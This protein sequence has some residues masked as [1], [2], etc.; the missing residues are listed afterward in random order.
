M[1]LD[2]L[3]PPD[4]QLGSLLL[5]ATAA[6]LTSILSAIVGMGG[7]ITL[8]A[9]MLVF[10]D[11]LVA[12]P[13]HAIIQLVSN[14]TRAVAQWQHVEWGIL[15]RYA[16]PLLPL[17]WLSLQ[18]AQEIP[19]NL[20]RAFIGVFVCVATWRPSWFLLGTHPEA[21]DSNRRFFGLGI[22]VGVFN[23][24]FG[25]T[26]PLI[27][28]FFLNLGLQ[29]FAIIGTKAAC[30]LAGHGVKI[31]V[32]GLAGFA[33]PDWLGALILLCGCVVVGTLVGTRMLKSVSEEIFIRLYKTVLTLVALYLIVRNGLMG[34]GA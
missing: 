26:G 12:I 32:F 27:A 22:V 3:V 34:W 20:A 7:G 16:L 21:I 4:L 18:L 33:Y 9:L 17:G 31:L 5:L 23:V 6:L 14:G 15:W 2:F 29:R 11:P 13:L 30:Q 8:L 25:A 1:I 19:P 28:P 24:T 10:L